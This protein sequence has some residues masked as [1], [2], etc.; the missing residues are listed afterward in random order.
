MVNHTCCLFYFLRD[1]A[2]ER[3]CPPLRQREYD[4]F[5]RKF[6]KDLVVGNLDKNRETGAQKMYPGGRKAGQQDHK[7]KRMWRRT[8]SSPWSSPS[9]GGQAQ[10]T[11]TVGST[12]RVATAPVVFLIPA[13]LMLSK[14]CP[15][16]V[17]PVLKDCA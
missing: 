15:I 7:Y 4:Q 6:F 3:V 17:G 14:F 16:H 12:C 8:L 9:D 5:L 11:T 2:A 13:H 10:E 1:K